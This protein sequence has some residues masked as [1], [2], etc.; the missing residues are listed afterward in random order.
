MPEGWN[1]SLVVD[2]ETCS[3][4]DDYEIDLSAEWLLFQYKISQKMF[5]HLNDRWFIIQFSYHLVVYIHFSKMLF[6]ISQLFI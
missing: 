5:P 3:D 1:G 6:L 2:V 4:Q